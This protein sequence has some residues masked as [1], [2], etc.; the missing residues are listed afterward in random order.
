MILAADRCVNVVGLAVEEATPLS[1]KH[2]S[3][4][5]RLREGQ[6]QGSLGPWSCRILTPGLKAAVGASG[7]CPLSGRATPSF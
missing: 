6:W 3:F 5:F 1:S 4:L 7:W 2:C